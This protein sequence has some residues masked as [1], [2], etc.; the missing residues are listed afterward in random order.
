MYDLDAIA[1]INLDQL[2]TATDRLLLGRLGKRRP[3]ARR[4]APTI[5]VDEKTL[6]VRGKT[7]PRRAPASLALAAML[8]GLAGCF[9]IAFIRLLA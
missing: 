1:A 8:G 7:P 3:L 2:A 5:V 9:A 6:Y 4:S